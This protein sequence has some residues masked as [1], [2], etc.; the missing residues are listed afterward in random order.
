MN[1][2]AKNLNIFQGVGILV[3]TLLG[4]SIFIIPA[5]AASL[6]GDKS[7]IAWILTILCILPVAATFGNLGAKYQNDGGTAYFIKKSFGDKF[8]RF[9]SWLYLSAL[10]ICP[11]IIVITGASYLGTIWGATQLQ[12][13]AICFAMLGGLF[14]INLVGMKFASKLQSFVSIFVVS[15]LLTLIVTAM[16][17]VDLTAHLFI[18]PVFGD[19]SLM[20]TTV[21][22]LFWCFVGLEA[23]VHIAGDFKNVTRDFPLT[24]F[25]S[26][27]IVGAICILLGL[28]VLRFHAFGSEEV[29]ANY[30]VFLFDVLLGSS[31]KIFVAIMAF[32]TCL[33]S[34][35]LYMISFAKML[36]TMSQSGNVSTKLC[37]VNKHHMP[38][39]ALLTCYIIAAST[40]VLKYAFHINLDAIILYANTIFVAI[41]LLASIAGIILLDGWK[42]HLAVIS[43]LFCSM[44][45]LSLGWK[46]FYIAALFAVFTALEYIIK[47]K[48]TIKI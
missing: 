16:F 40:I 4:S 23:V 17:K 14:A 25:I 15:I 13:I 3:S 45:F 24:I 1:T 8:E 9:T 29:N 19:I 32:F 39:N 48:H 46:C 5:M 22:L 2:N 33:S 28:I 12:L 31:G 20:K 37:K 21:A 36:H 30:I 42:K 11:P 41:Y 35:N 6:A 7:I 18:Q 26:L 10:P 44:I 34:I 38:V 27:L 43:T 47:Q